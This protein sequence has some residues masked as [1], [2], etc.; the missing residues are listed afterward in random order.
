MSKHSR[1]IQKKITVTLSPKV[2]SRKNKSKR[3]GRLVLIKYSPASQSKRIQASLSEVYGPWPEKLSQ[4]ITSP[5]AKTES[6]RRMNKPK[7][8]VETILL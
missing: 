2:V 1:I 8:R 6:Q 3:H 7:R 4:I 5:L